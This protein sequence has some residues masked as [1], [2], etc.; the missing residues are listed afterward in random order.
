MNLGALVS[1]TRNPAT[2][3]LDEM[4]TLDMV[5]CFNQEDRKVPEPT[6]N[7]RTQTGQPVIG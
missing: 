6:R 1:E 5:R 2:M 7:D 3:G 4:S